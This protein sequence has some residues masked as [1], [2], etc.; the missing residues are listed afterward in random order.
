MVCKGDITKEKSG[1][2]FFHLKL[3]LINVYL[4]DETFALEPNASIKNLKNLSKT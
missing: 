3:C 4:R 1:I 2:K